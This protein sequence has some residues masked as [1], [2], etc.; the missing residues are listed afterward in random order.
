MAR[1]GQE[2]VVAGAAEAAGAVDTFKGAGPRPS[3]RARCELEVAG[4]EE[5]LQLSPGGLGLEL[6][7]FWGG[8]D[9]SLFWGR[10]DDV[11]V[12][13]TAAGGGLALKSMTSDGI[14]AVELEAIVLVSRATPR[15]RGRG[16]RGGTRGATRGGTLP[17]PLP[18]AAPLPMPLPLPP[19]KP[20][21]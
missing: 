19:R 17:M 12:E 3:R 20:A 1:P 16:M 7:F 4:E 15:G 13:S 18:M 9:E 8:E 2:L 6:P 14:V 21:Q 11:G 10:G 5:L